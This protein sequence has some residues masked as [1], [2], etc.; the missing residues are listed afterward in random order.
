MVAGVQLIAAE[1]A[2]GDPV[3]DALE[4]P[5][6]CCEVGTDVVVCRL[7]EARR[8]RDERLAGLHR[9]TD[10]NAESCALGVG[11]ERMAIA[12]QRVPEDAPRH[13]LKVLVAPRLGRLDLRAGRRIGGEEGRVGLNAVELTGDLAR[14]LDLAIVELERRH[15]DAVEARQLAAS[16]SR[17]P[18]SGR[19]A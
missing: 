10:R 13:A 12:A 3:V 16:P 14:A 2:C 18:A 11:R 5:R 7:V 19:R 8:E 15:R 9:E 1:N 4:H 6:E 17:P